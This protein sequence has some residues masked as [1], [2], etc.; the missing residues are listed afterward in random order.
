LAG[1]A[2][3]VLG[4]VGAWVAVWFSP[5]AVQPGSTNRLADS[6]ASPAFI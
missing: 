1:V 5:G 3:V 2:V 4:G 6:N